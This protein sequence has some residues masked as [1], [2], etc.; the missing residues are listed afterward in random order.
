[1]TFLDLPK[2]LQNRIKA[3]KIS[4]SDKWVKEPIPAL[5]NK[6][7]LEVL[8]LKDGEERALKYLRKLEEYYL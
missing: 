8:S 5:D 7:L 3:L 2:Y 6:S 1:M 4:D